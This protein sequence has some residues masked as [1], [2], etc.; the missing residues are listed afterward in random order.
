VPAT[1]QQ[2]VRG[3]SDLLLTLGTLIFNRSRKLRLRPGEE[4]GEAVMVTA[5][6]GIMET[7][8][9]IPINERKHQQQCV[10]DYSLAISGSWIL[11]STYASFGKKL[12]QISRVKQHLSRIHAPIY[13]QRCLL[14]FVNEEKLQDHLSSEP[15]RRDGSATL[16]GIL[17]KQRRALSRKSKP[18]TSNEDKWSAIWQ[19]VFPEHPRPC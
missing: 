18:N 2:I 19:I 13:C 8:H 9:I 17:Q 4:G 10:A 16:E 12:D 3:I 14:V 5:I 6:M 11:R 7:R 15:C 1:L